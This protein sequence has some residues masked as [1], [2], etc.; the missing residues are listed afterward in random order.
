MLA[1]RPCIDDLYSNKSLF[2]LVLLLLAA[3]VLWLLHLSSKEPTGRWQLQ[4]A[5][6]SLL[7][8]FCRVYGFND[9]KHCQQLI[10]C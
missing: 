1:A 8:R 3:E 10:L 4:G 5:C 9:S 7:L 6:T 2:R